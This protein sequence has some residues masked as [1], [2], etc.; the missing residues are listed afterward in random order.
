VGEFL[1]GGVL[2]AV[3]AGLIGWAGVAVRRRQTIAR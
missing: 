2:L 1:A 3:G